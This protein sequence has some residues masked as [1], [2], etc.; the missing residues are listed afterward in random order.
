LP[1]TESALNRSGRKPKMQSGNCGTGSG[2]MRAGGRHTRADFALLIGAC[3]VVLGFTLV[4]RA[5]WA[6]GDPE[7][8][9]RLAQTWCSSCHAAADATSATDAAPSL[10]SIARNR[11][12][13]T[14]WLRSWLV[15]PHPR[16]PNFNLSEAEID[17]LVA[18]LAQL[19][20]PQ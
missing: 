13:D 12:Q 11:A 5:A 16:M 3:S 4:Q 17:D 7:A 1:K 9:H 20:Q 18:Y 19:A 6:D 14:G 10:A 8:G 2:M 15:A